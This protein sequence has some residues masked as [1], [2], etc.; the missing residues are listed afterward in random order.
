MLLLDLCG[1]AQK[2]ANEGNAL[3]A[4]RFGAEGAINHGHCPILAIGLGVKVSVGDPVAE[5]YVHSRPSPKFML[6][7]YSP[8]EQFAISTAA[9]AMRRVELPQPPR[10]APPPLLTTNMS[11]SSCNSIAE[12]LWDFACTTQRALGA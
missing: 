7:I 10:F 6:F 4:L 1:V 11:K 12:K 9:L 2:L 8:C 5:T 3:A